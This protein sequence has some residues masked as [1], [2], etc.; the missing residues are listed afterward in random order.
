VGDLTTS[1]S[2]HA[3]LKNR[4]SPVSRFL[5][6]PWTRL[7][8]SEHRKA[9][10]IAGLLLSLALLGFV[11]ALVQKA[12]VPGFRTT[13][14]IVVSAIAVIAL[15][16]VASRTRLHRLGAGVACAVPTIAC[17]IVAIKNPHDGA[18]YVFMLLGVVFSTL[19]FSVKVATAVAGAV[20]AVVCA[21]VVW[22][23][24]LRAPATF[25]PILA[26]H[27]VMSPLLLV[28][29][30]HQGRL[31]RERQDDLRRRDARLAGMAG[32]EVLASVVGSIVHDFNNLL[33]VVMANATQ[34]EQEGS[35]KARERAREIGIAGDTAVA[36]GRQL[37]AFASRQPSQPRKL[38]LEEV[39]RRIEPILARMAEGVTLVVR[40]AA[41][42]A[43]VN[44]DPLQLEQVLMNLVV[45]ARDAMPN[46]GVITI[47]MENVDLDKAYVD[48]HPEAHACAHVMT[49]VSDTG[50]GMDA[51]TRSRAFDPFFTTKGDKGSGLGLATVRGVVKQAGGHVTVSSELG[52]GTTFR[53]YL[54]RVEGAGQPAERR[55][56]VR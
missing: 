5:V 23:P 43:L 47:E 1:E 49:V 3:G 52:V 36:L 31:E 16:Y 9:Q 4:P 21:L 14:I 45:N 38:N 22:V 33:I 11:V 48:L 29:A 27:I 2:G 8:A 32:M 28:A 6:D 18:W 46:G 15:G 19:F 34:L 41:N 12:T 35:E 50:A 25:A 30:Y 10:L 44:A 54:P 42:L 13:F 17:A 7:D 51:L 55:P 39:V 37:L 24:E 56:Q 40:S 53:V 20:F 26:V